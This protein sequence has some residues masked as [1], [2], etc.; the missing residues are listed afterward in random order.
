MA[1]TL[2]PGCRA[3]LRAG[4][5]FC[6]SCGAAVDPATQAALSRGAERKRAREAPRDDAAAEDRAI[7]G[8]RLNE[9]ARKAA[10][11]IAGIAVLT[12]LGG[13]L[14][15]FLARQE[16]D[17]AL[18]VLSSLDPDLVL[19]EKIDGVTYTVRELRQKVV[20]EPLQ[21]L[22]VN[23]ALAVVFGGIYLWSRR[24]AV[25]PAM[26]TAM[27][28]FAVVHFVSFVVDPKTLVQGIVVKVLI[29]SAL[30]KGIRTAKAA[31]EH[32]PTEPT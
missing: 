11:I 28:V 30:V 3:R 32:E 18:A 19:P 7:I 8:R 1:K 29:I 24:G 21:V 2:C 14:M 10:Q 12:L 31:R 9:A 20:A 4:D 16:A 6:E 15:Y 26:L 23:G 27:A 13:A 17:K 25:Y 5:E 22:L